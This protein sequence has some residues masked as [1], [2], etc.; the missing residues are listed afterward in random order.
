M[1][2]E[3]RGHQQFYYRSRRMNGRVVKIYYG[4]GQRAK[5]AYEIDQQRQARR[6]QDCA[7]RKHIQALDLQTDTLNQTTRTLVKASFLVAGYH[8]HHRG[9]W[10]KRRRQ[11]ITQQEGDSMIQTSALQ[12]TLSIDTLESLLQRA[13]KGDEASLLII[14]QL[15]DQ[16]P[17]IFQEVF[18]IT[19][20]VETAWIQTIAGKDLLTRETLERQVATLKMR[21][22]TE[23][24]SPL[25][26]L[27]IETI[28]T[29]WLA[30]KQAELSAAQQIQRNNG[31]GLTQGQQNHLTA[32]QKRYLSAI[33]ELARIRQLLT[34]PKNTTVVNIADKQQVNM[35]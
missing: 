2:W 34:T 14:K 27:I 19:K 22:E 29:T 33:R 25:E 23:S 4:T 10:R 21:L 32:C 16:A 28:C 30:Y 7:T 9:E 12:E 15:L 3:T 24:S 6:E 31:I 35:S 11:T 18:S 26:H 20:K 1:A 17:A 8:Q 13:T 5:Q